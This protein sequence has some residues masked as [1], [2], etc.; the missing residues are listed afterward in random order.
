MEN[1]ITDINDLVL[2]LTS[3][4]MKPLLNDEIWQC[5]GY[6]K[7]PVKGNMWNKLFPKK[8][9]LENLIT[10]EILTMGLI[11]VLNGIKKSDK[12]LET[13]LLISIGIIDQFLST[14]KHLFSSNLFME[15]LFSTYTSFLRSDKS[16]LHEP[17]I[18]KA[19]DALEKKNFAKFMIGTIKLLAIEQH[20][21]FILNSNYIKNA[22]DNSAV[23]NELKI[24]MS[25]EKW[26]EYGALL[27]EQIL[28][29]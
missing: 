28:N 15:N 14:T 26:R 21:D 7:R 24:S 11:D 27:S 12:T 22:V 29:K 6:K 13:K 8:F 18:L 25:K 19:K 16:K 3:T 1:K 4:A 17:F 23:E 10:K 2:F 5:Y 9:E 20:D